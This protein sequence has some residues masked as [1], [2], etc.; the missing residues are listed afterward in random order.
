MMSFIDQDG[1]EVGRGSALF[2]AGQ[3]WGANIAMIII[4]PDSNTSSITSPPYIACF[5]PPY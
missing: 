2:C 5:M 4:A 3:R 1:M